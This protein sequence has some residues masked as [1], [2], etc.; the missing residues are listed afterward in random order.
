MV[1]EKQI[2]MYVRTQPYSISFSLNENEIEHKKQVINLYCT[3]KVKVLLHTLPKTK[4]SWNMI[5]LLTA[6]NFSGSMV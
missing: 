1:G 4:I 6:T 5:I 3:E 2:I